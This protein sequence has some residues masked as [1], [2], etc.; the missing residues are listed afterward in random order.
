MANYSFDHGNVHILCLDANVYVYP[1]EQELLK[2]IETDLKNSQATWKLVAFH[3]PGFNSSNA[4][5]NA[6]WMHALSPVFERRRVDMVLNGHVHNYQR[7][8]PLKFEPKHVL[9]VSL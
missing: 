7:S 2:W 6:Q 1:F 3:H 5:Y 9:Q 8:R 4:H